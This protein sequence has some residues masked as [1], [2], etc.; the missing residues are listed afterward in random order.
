MQALLDKGASPDLTDAAGTSALGLAQQQD[1][2]L[3]ELLSRYS[4]ATLAPVAELAAPTA[5]PAM[6]SA[7]PALEP[8]AGLTAAGSTPASGGAEAPAVPT[9][10]P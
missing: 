6:L 7:P 2:Q 8:Q 4:G 10:Q 3:V 9:P 1:P 5:E